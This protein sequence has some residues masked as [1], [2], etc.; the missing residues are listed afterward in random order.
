MIVQYVLLI[1]LINI[2]VCSPD[3]KQ[4]CADEYSDVLLPFLIPLP[5]DR[6]RLSDIE[7]CVQHST[8]PARRMMSV[9]VY[10]LNVD[11][12]DDFSQRLNYTVNVLENKIYVTLRNVTVDDDGMYKCYSRHDVIHECEIKLNVNSNKQ[13]SVVPNSWYI[14]DGVNFNVTC[15]D[16]KFD[17][18]HKYPYYIILRLFRKSVP[19]IQ[20]HYTFEE[21]ANYNMRKDET[22]TMIRGPGKKWKFDSASKPTRLTLIVVGAEKDDSGEYAC[23]TSSSISEKSGVLMTFYSLIALVNVRAYY[24]PTESCECQDATIS[25][26]DEKNVS[27]C[28]GETFQKKAGRISEYETAKVDIDTD[29]GQF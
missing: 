17:H 12:S 11:V 4:W 23:V 14:F 7:V 18:G 20:S 26:T 22:T 15:E 5:D 9:N 1:G 2:V 27:P 19:N 24:Q 3:P 6:G 13:Q 25:Y 8:Q 29:S 16:S 21:V 10:S 28:R